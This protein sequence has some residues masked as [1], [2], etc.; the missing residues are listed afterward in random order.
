LLERHATPGCGG[1]EEAL[2]GRL[3]ALGLLHLVPELRHKSLVG[4]KGGRTVLLALDAVE[5]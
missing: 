4:D 3:E 5:P 1:E 2:K